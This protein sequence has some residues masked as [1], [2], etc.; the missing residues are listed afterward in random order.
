MWHIPDGDPYSAS[1]TYAICQANGITPVVVE[2]SLHKIKKT[3]GKGRNKFNQPDS[4]C[5]LLFVN[6]MSCH[7]SFWILFCNSHQSRY[8][9]FIQRLTG[10]QQIMPK[11]MCHSKY[12]IIK[13]H[14]WLFP[15][16]CENIMSLHFETG[17][18]GF[19]QI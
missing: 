7:F 14:S 17:T 8:F 10:S 4:L 1:L 15:L 11:A 2:I 12:S 5:M 16:V 13:C 19:G 18:N 9:A 3:N 6:S